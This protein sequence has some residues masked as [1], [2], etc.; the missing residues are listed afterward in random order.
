MLKKIPNQSKDDEFFYPNRKFSLSPRVENIVM[1]FLY[2]SGEEYNCCSDLQIFGDTSKEDSKNS[3]E[4]NFNDHSEWYQAKISIAGFKNC[5]V[6]K[7]A[8]SDLW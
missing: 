6:G 5:Y 1:N 2:G 7:V 8:A 3:T 4:E